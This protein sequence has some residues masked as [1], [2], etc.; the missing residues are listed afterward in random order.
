MK[1]QFSANVVVS[2]IV[3]AIVL[4][5]AVVHFISVVERPRFPFSTGAHQGTTVVERIEI[6]DAS[7]NLKTGDIVVSLNGYE[8]PEPD[9]FT[10]TAELSRIGT[11]HSLK[12]HRQSE[13][14]V[15]QTTL[16]PYYSGMSL[17]IIAI[18]GI[19]FVV[20]GVTVLIVKGGLQSARALHWSLVSVGFSVFFDWGVIDASGGFWIVTRLLFFFWYATAPVALMHFVCVFPRQI[21]SSARVRFLATYVVVL[22]IGGICAY[23]HLLAIANFS[24]IEYRS[25]VDWFNVFHVVVV[26]YSIYAMYYL[27]RSYKEAQSTEERLQIKWVGWGIAVGILPFL[28]LIVL[29]QLF[30]SSSPIPEDIGTLFFLAAP[31]SFTIAIVRHRLFDIEVLIRR[32]TVYGIALILVAGTY[33]AAITLTVALLGSFVPSM[34]LSTIFAVIIAFLF[35]RGKR[36]VQNAVDRAFFKTSY[37]FRRAQA[38]FFA[39]VSKI[40]RP[41][42]LAD[43]CIQSLNESLLPERIAFVS[44]THPAHRLTLLSDNG[45]KDEWDERLR[46]HLRAIALSSDPAWF[47]RR[48]CELDVKASVLDPLY[49]NRHIAGVIVARS[50]SGTTTG[51]LLLGPKKSGLRYSVQDTDFIWTIVTHTAL[52]LD[53]MRVRQ[54]LLI[55]QSEIERLEELDRLRSDFVS[56]VSHDLKTPLTSMRLSV[57]RLFTSRLSAAK[58]GKYIRTLTREID[59]FARLL[60]NVLNYSK[61]ERGTREYILKPLDLNTLMRNSYA[62]MEEQLESEGFDVHWHLHRGRIIVMGDADA[63]IEAFTNIIS[64]SIKYSGDRKHLQFRTG[65]KQHKAIASISDQGIGI[66]PEDQHKIFQPFYRVNNGLVKSRG[67]TGLGLALVKHIIEAH[68][69]NIRLESAPDKGTTFSLTFSTGIPNDKDTAG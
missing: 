36:Y 39:D 30:F 50:E 48:E 11:S 46:T 61:M 9:F 8:N 28:L 21:V 68:G 35:E 7:L 42:T 31:I 38:L 4:A 27:A 22:M 15:C 57:E 65:C 66:P 44:F 18:V 54:Q 3:D 58:K 40:D 24:P 37:D 59:R 60:D 47:D 45:F 32:S 51:L 5:V 26:G 34:Y 20:S 33:I 62:I 64:N 56:A 69:A 29:P 67:G 25:F 63:L 10:L 16:V 13:I 23:H 55:E 41:R 53:R 2:L 52:S 19:G 17:F 43:F 6:R 49:S 14:F 12:L 1:I